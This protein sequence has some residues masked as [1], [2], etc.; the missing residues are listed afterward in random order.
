MV[1]SSAADLCDVCGL[2]AD[3]CVCDSLDSEAVRITVKVDQRR[4]KKSMTIITFEGEIKDKKLK[5]L[6]K[7]AKSFFASGGTLKDNVIE[8][9]GDHKNKVREFLRE[10]GFKDSN[11]TIL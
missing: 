1:K 10:N 7:N 4:Y 2:P 11:V 9:Q 5:S 3:F 8:I 6:V